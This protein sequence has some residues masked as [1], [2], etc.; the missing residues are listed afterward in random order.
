MST[1]KKAF[2]QRQHFLLSEET[3]KEAKKHG[4]KRKVLRLAKW[5]TSNNDK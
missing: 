2:I 4:N 1:A 5:Q 3:R